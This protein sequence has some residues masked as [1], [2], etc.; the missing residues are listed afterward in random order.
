M[1]LPFSILNPRRRHEKVSPSKIKKRR[2]CKKLL[3]LQTL[4]E[5]AAPTGVADLAEIPMLPAGFGLGAAA[6]Q[7][8]IEGGQKAEEKEQKVQKR[9][10]RDRPVQQED[11]LRAKSEEN[12]APSERRSP[13]QVDASSYRQDAG[14]NRIAADASQGVSDLLVGTGLDAP[15]EEASEPSTA[16]GPPR[17]VRP[18]VTS[19]V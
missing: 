15:A 18:N 1:R 7:N 8:L 11:G 17:T 10:R 19:A 12:F 13:R 2:P 14:R 4:E 3:G 5:R 16:S 6:I 9:S